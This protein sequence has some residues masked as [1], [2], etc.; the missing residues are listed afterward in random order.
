M[1]ITLNG[2]MIVALLALAGAILNIIATVYLARRRADFDAQV[3]ELKSKFDQLNALEMA[4]VQANNSVKLKELENRFSRETELTERNRQADCVVMGKIIGAVE[5]EHSMSFLRSHDF[6]GTFDREDLKPVRRLLNL[7]EDVSCEFLD[8]SLEE[9]RLLVIDAAM[10]FSSS[11]SL[12]T[13]P[14]H[15]TYSSVVPQAEVNTDYSSR[16]FAAGKEINENA[17]KFVN[18]F[19]ELMRRARASHVLVDQRGN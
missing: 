7:A 5:P 11:V 2:P 13:F 9:L 3:V 4:Q 19:E 16:F 10:K 17:T 18:T 14:R 6:N 1:N 8:P 15:G 12:K